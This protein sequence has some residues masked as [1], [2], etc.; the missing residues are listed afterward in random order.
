MTGLAS[1]LENDAILMS[2]PT[3]VVQVASWVEEQA[4]HGIL[5]AS[6]VC[7]SVKHTFDPSAISGRS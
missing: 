5:S 7:E 3:Y 6:E 2:P 1:N 4:A